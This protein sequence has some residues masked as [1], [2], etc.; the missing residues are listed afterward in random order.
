MNKKVYQSPT[1]T[2]CTIATANMI[3]TSLGINNT[4]VSDVT[5]LSKNRADADILDEIA[6]SSE[7]DTWGSVW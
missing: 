4:E 7:E 6:A 2:L 3:A 5:G 1:I